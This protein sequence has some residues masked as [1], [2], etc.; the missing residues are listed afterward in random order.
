[1]YVCI[2]CIFPY[3]PLLTPPF[4]L[5][6]R[7]KE[8]LTVERFQPVVTPRGPEMIV[9]YDEHV[10]VNHFKFGLIYQ[11]AGQT[12]EEQ[13]FGNKTHSPA[14]EEFLS[15]MGQRVKLRDHEG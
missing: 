8:E 4:L 10:L 13:L 14:F 9:A 3:R 5:P 1:M 7:L 15:L 6:Q 12:T 2:S 11:R